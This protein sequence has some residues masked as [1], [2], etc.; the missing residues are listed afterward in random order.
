MKKKI[1]VSIDEETIDLL[2]DYVDKGTFRNKS[3]LIEFALNKYLEG[4]N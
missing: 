3:H 1:S 2:K 4:T